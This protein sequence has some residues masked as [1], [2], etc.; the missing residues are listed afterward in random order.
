MVL[1][2]GTILTDNENGECCRLTPDSHGSYLNGTWVQ[3]ASMNYSRM[4][5]A[6]AVLTNGN[7]F[8]AGGEDGQRKP[9]RRIV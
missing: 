3:V 4:F 1:S 7:E 8:V 9:P 5:F 2:D 6:S